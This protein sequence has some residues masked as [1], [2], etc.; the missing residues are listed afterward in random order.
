MSAWFAGVDL[1]PCL[2]IAEKLN[3]TLQTINT[4]TD[5]IRFTKEEEKDNQ[6]PFLDVLLSKNNDSTLNTQV[7]R[8]NTHTDQV[9]NYHS[10]H[11]TQ[12]K[13]SCIRT[14]YNR[15]ETHCNTVQSKEE[16]RKYLHDMF[17]KN[18][19]PVNFIHKHSN[20]KKKQP[21]TH[22]ENTDQSPQ[23][24]RATLPHIHSTSE[25]TA[26]IL[27][28]HNLPIAHK[29]SNKIAMYFTK[30]KD[31]V[32]TTDKRNAI[33]MFNCNDC[34]QSY[35]S[36]TSKKVKTRL[37]EHKNAIKRHDPRSTPCGKSLVK[38]PETFL[39]VFESIQDTFWT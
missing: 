6:L 25:M 33:Y 34:T 2:L 24:K 3:N 17:I 31:Q 30:H 27:R 10:N 12:H 9:L 32:T 38:V 7:H 13:I 37:T 20:T 28:K 22:Q 19:Y 5:N 1:G 16:E 23:E 29:P 26:Q 11:P 39:L 18:N 35:I 4:T 14:L 21:K 15:I 8:K 36:E